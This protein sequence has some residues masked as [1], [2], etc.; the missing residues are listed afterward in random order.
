MILVRETLLALAHINEKYSYDLDRDLLRRPLLGPQAPSLPARQQATRYFPTSS[1]S[2]TLYAHDTC[3]SYYDTPIFP[4][5]T[6]KPKGSGA[7]L[8]SH[9]TRPIFNAGSTPRYDP[10]HS[11][12]HSSSIWQP[13]P[14]SVN[15]GQ[16]TSGVHGKAT[17]LTVCSTAG[18]EFAVGRTN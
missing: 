7:P 3:D 1:S 6:L 5:P 9:D 13:E 4:N 8:D 10:E 11:T 12:A 17:L 15:Y 2:G 16:N 18:P 14:T